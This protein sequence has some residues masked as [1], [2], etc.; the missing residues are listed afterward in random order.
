MVR[1]RGRGSYFGF[2]VCCGGHTF[3]TEGIGRVIL[4]ISEKKKIS[5]NYAY[6]AGKRIIQKC[7]DDVS[8]VCVWGGHYLHFVLVG[9]RYIL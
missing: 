6:N 9:L 5:F 7:F 8:C 3:E 2:L 4:L 1:F